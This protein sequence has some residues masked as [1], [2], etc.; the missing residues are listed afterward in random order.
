M[1]FKETKTAENLLKSF[2]GECQARMRYE[3]SAKTAKKEGFVQISEIFTETA[4]N[5]KEHAK[6]FFRHLLKNGMEGDDINIMAS[7]PV[8]WSETG[9]ATL[10]NLEFAANG[11]K[12]EWTELYPTFADIA[13]EEG[14]KE[15]AVAWRMIARVE[16]EHEKRFRKLYDNVKNMTVFK[17]DEKV[18]WKCINCGYI[19]EGETPPKICPS[20]DHP[21]DYF[22]VHKENY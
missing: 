13:E 11:E 4:L 17:K 12:E 21:K 1:S 8:G 18:F 5:E 15:I 7:Y 19:H 16:K 10:K 2:A 3:Y 22:E 6:V 14:Y 20:C 9:D